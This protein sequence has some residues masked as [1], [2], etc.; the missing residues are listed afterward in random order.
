MEASPPAP[1]AA[2]WKRDFF[3]TALAVLA[4][5]AWFAYLLNTGNPHPR[6]LGVTVIGACTMAALFALKKRDLLLFP[7]SAAL[8]GASFFFMGTLEGVVLA[9]VGAPI[10]IMALSFGVLHLLLHAIS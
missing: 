9:A 8:T 5:A 4:I 10:G 7:L 3:R 1:A 6:W 2:P